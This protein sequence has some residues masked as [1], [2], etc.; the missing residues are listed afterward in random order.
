MNVSMYSHK[1]TTHNNTC[2]CLGVYVGIF[3]TSLL[4]WN[5]LIC[6]LILF[7]RS[8]YSSF[9]IFNTHWGHVRYR[10]TVVFIHHNTHLQVVHFLTVFIFSA[11]VWG[12]FSWL[13]I[14]QLYKK[15]FRQQLLTTYIKPVLWTKVITIPVLL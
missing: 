10:K 8:W 6:R 12:F 14:L 9:T 4:F 11:P 7:Y 13:S 5:T 2:A 3:K 1:Y 15:P